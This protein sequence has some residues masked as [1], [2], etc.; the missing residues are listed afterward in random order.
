MALTKQ[1]KE[2]LVKKIEGALK[3]EKATVFFD[4]T[5]L[6]LKKL[7]ELRKKLKSENNS[8]QIVKKT[9]LKLALKNA[10]REAPIQEFQSS[11]AMANSNTDEILPSKIVYNFSKTNEA[12]KIL[13]GILEQKFITGKEVIA[14]AKLPPKEQMI[15]NT[16]Y[17]IASPLTNFVTLL[18]NNIRS[19]VYVLTNI[20]NNKK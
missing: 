16:V 1:K 7:Q 2:E 11:I 3:E 6:N 10:K 12:V 15:A 19:I 18:Q 17:A 8:L 9:L 4:F 5:G 14:L 20:N 13:G